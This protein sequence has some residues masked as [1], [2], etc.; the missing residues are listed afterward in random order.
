VSHL[1]AEVQVQGS[2]VSSYYYAGG[3]RVAMLDNGNLYYLFADHLGST[4]VV[5]NSS[6][7]KTAE[8]RYKAWGEDR[9]TSGTVPSG[10][11]FTGQRVEASLGL[12]YYGARWY[13][14]YLNRWIQPDTIIPDPYNPQGWDRYTYVNNNPVR[15][16]D[17]SGHC[18]QVEDDLCLRKD[19]NNQLH[20]VQA[21][22][23]RFRNDVERAIA[24]AILSGDPRS[25]NRIPEGSPGFMVGAALE[26]ACAGLGLDC[27][28]YYQT[29]IALL[30][31]GSLV[32]AG[33][34]FRPSTNN[35]VPSSISTDAL[36]DPDCPG[37][38]YQTPWTWRWGSY[39]S[40]QKWANQMVQRGWTPDQINEAIRFGQRFPAINNIN[41]GHSAT[42][43]VNPTT[44][45]SVVIDDVTGEII[46]IG[47]DDFVYP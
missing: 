42:R 36:G 47:G 4:S 12:Y 43:Y 30:T 6:G 18:I 33:G 11:R 8:V 41:P 31:T 44:G 9:Y 28:N 32:I 37:C 24:D 17:P 26:N 46:H 15:Y 2:V 22:K 25:L 1:L 7:S 38:G 10:Y 21:G 19:D 45:R 39:K 3:Q 13:D 35:V 20:I 14:A 34:S 27:G 23:N 16:T 40:P 5:A 29:F